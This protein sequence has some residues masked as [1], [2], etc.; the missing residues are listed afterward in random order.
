ML[1]LIRKVYN[2]TTSVV[3]YTTKTTISTT[4]ATA[5]ATTKTAI[6][7]AILSVALT[8]IILESIKNSKSTNTKRV[9]VSSLVHFNDTQARSDQ[10]AKEY[11]ATLV[12]DAAYMNAL[13]KSLES[14]NNN[15]TTTTSVPIVDDKHVLLGTVVAATAAA[16]S[17]LLGSAVRDL[18]DANNTSSVSEELVDQN[19]DDNNIVSQEVVNDKIDDVQHTAV[20][21][22]TVKDNNDTS[23][24]QEVTSDRAVDV[25]PVSESIVHDEPVDAVADSSVHDNVSASESQ[26]CVPE[27]K[28]REIFPEPVAIEETTAESTSE[29][30]KIDNDNMVMPVSDDD[31][32]T[33]TVLDVS[34]VDKDISDR[35]IPQVDESNDVD[36]VSDRSINDENHLVDDF[37]NNNSIPEK[38]N[39][40]LSQ[41]TNIEVVEEPIAFEEP[42]TVKEPTTTVKEPISDEASIADEVSTVDVANEET[43]GEDE[44]QISNEDVV[45]APS[46]SED[47][48]TS[49]ESTATT[50]TTESH[51]NIKEFTSSREDFISHLKAMT[52]SVN[53]V[54]SVDDEDEQSI[55]IPS[56]HSTTT[57]EATNESQS[58]DS[59]PSPSSIS[60]S[61]AM[62]SPELMVDTTSDAATYLSSP[63]V[64]SSLSIESD[65]DIAETSITDAP[66]FAVQERKTR[67]MMKEMNLNT[68]NK[69]STT[70]I[71]PAEAETNLSLSTKDSAAVP[72][73]AAPA[74]TIITTSTEPV[75]ANCIY[76]PNCTNKKC[77][78]MHSGDENVAVPKKTATSA[79]VGQ[80]NGKRVMT[81]TERIERQARS[82]PPVWKSRC[83]HWP[84]CTNNNCKYSHPVKECR[85]GE[86]CNYK[87]RCMFLHP[88]D[89]VEPSARRKK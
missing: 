51:V 76:Y 12:S 56:E 88:S 22:E 37:V 38:D 89:L 58:L 8:I 28:D 84:K 71:V 41:S 67:D 13:K 59:Q 86:N 33:T 19:L 65:K 42:T 35:D 72:S 81:W 60:N 32:L 77:K 45:M 7:G 36:I 78:Y 69:P 50:V 49:S 34:D 64:A 47:T 11:I 63:S 62:S 40:E 44:A 4:I 74:T 27:T 29:D 15:T 26:P 9:S 30:V 57:Y 53:D 82:H 66:Y 14:L 46:K 17:V 85:M 87:S 55:I 61:E 5:K 39:A 6:G 70:T 83:V 79:S 68:D 2:F 48:V 25:S 21:Q 23:V 24:P 75:T 73:P 52:P 1:F 80:K 43:I 20:A 18:V 16:G 10:K 31:I 54:A 3:S